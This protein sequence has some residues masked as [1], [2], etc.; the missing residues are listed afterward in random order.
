MLKH[1]RE[2]RLKAEFATLYVGVTPNEW[3]PI[4]ELLDSVAATRLLSRRCSASSWQGGHWT[5]GISSS[6]GGRIGPRSAPYGPAGRPT[7]SAAAPGDG[8]SIW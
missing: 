3:R 4:G 5:S 1:R 2:A 7:P 8:L 6:A